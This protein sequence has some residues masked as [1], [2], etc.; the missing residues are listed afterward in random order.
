MK[1]ARKSN[2]ATDKTWHLN[3]T[4]VPSSSAARRSLLMMRSRLAVVIFAGTCR[5]G[6]VVHSTRSIAVVGD[7]RLRLLGAGRDD[8]SACCSRRREYIVRLLG[9]WI[10]DKQR[11]GSDGAVYRFWDL[12]AV[13]QFAYL[14]ATQLDQFG[15]PG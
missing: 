15:D 8:S 14:N 3:S 11:A 13:S 4:A 1:H 6:T 10:Q 5:G 7:G 2:H 9:T 12:V